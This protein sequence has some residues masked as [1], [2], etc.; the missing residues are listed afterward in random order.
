MDTT[1]V[2]P[3]RALMTPAQIELSLL[4]LLP[5][6]ISHLERVLRGIDAANKSRLETCWR[7]IRVGQLQT[8]TELEATELEDFANV[9]ELVG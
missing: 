3:R 5:E 1:V 6:A 2:E 7:I 9:L 8:A 4:Q